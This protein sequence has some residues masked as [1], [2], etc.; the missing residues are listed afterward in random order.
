[1]TMILSDADVID[2]IFTHL[3]AK[4]TDV[5]ESVWRE[6][7]EN[8]RSEEHFHAEIEILRRLPVPFC[9]SAALPE[10]GSFVARTAALTPIVVVRGDDG[11]VRAFR[12]SCRHRGMAVANGNGCAR[13]FVC[14]YHS[15]TYG[16]EGNLKHIPGRE[17]FPGV[18]M[19]E[20]GLVPVKAEE[21]G[22][23]IFVTQE[24]PISNGVLD[25]LPDIL[26]P[27]Q[28]MFD[29]GEYVDEANWKLIAETS[30]EGYHIK[31]LHN[32]TFYPYGL[33]NVNVVEIFGTNSRIIFPFRRINKL[34]DIPREKRRINGMTTDVYQLFPN[35][36]LS[37]LSNH[38][39]L[40]V[41]EPVSPTETRSIV[42]RMRNLD[43]EGIPVDLDVAKRDAG[44]VKNSGIE[45]DR[46]AARSIQAGLN[47]NANSHFTFGHYEKAIVHFHEMLN[48]HLA[49]RNNPDV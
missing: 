45:E 24:A 27:R 14:P 41:L 38:T 4:T 43:T 5:G 29:H 12:N 21:R 23:L 46:D 17:G 10:K 16:L 32:R 25:A 28:D 47:S 3:D 2:R 49:K 40:I 9:P 48:E 22:G 11:V 1:M 34:R 37:V 31:S 39:Q 18:D 20:H 42:Y 35:S 33:D 7:V 19:S 36:H 30:M 8:Y 26:D 13:A 15:W 44:F 6:P